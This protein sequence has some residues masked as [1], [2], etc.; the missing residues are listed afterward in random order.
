[1][2]AVHVYSA[3]RASSE[4]IFSCEF[5]DL[6]PE[7]EHYVLKYL[8]E[9]TFRSV[10]NQLRIIGHNAVKESGQAILVIKKVVHTA[11]DTHDSC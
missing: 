3:P 9:L 7:K 2:S 5:F 1:M 11:A 6:V 10:S 8:C 4:P